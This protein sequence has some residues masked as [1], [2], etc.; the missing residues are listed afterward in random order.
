MANEVFKRPCATI[1]PQPALATPAPTK[2]PT[3]ACEDDDGMPNHQVM[4]FHEIAPLS[5]PKMT[6]LSI[7]SFEMIPLP[8]VSATCRPKN[9]KATKLKNA[10]QTTA[11]CGVSSRVETMRAIEFAAS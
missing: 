10:A 11:A 5:A 8:T 3:K 9:K 7:I 1:A 6:A 2:P 4:R